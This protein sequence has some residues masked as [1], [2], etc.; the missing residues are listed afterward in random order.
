MFDKLFD[1]LFANIVANT[2]TNPGAKKQTCLKF[3]RTL[4]GLAAH[5]FR[6]L[7]LINTGMQGNQQL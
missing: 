7:P 6:K 2:E 3:F 1:N 4:N 5:N